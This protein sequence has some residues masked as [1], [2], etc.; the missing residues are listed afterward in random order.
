MSNKFKRLEIANWRQFSDV[1][2]DFDERMTI[3]TGANGAGKTTILN[4]LS[5]HFGWS[6]NFIGTRSLT[7]R[8]AWKYFSG[9][10]RD[11][12]NLDENAQQTIGSLTYTDGQ[13]SQLTVSP[14][15]TE[16]FQVQVASQ[17]PVSGIYITSHRPVYSYQRVDQIPTTIIAADQLF[18]DYVS[19]LR[20][21]YTPQ[22][23]IQSPSFRLKTALISLATFGYGNKA[24]E[25][26]ENA[27][28][29]FE[30]FQEVLRKILPPDLEFREIRI[31][32]PDVLIHCKHHDFSIDAASG[33]VSALIDLAW[34]I[35]MKGQSTDDFVVVLDEPENHLHPRLQRTVLPS[36]ID[37]FPQAQFIAATHNPFV[38]TSVADSS[39]VVLDFQDGKVVSEN[40][41]A[42]DK[43]A[44]ANQVLMDVL[45]V[46]FP[47][48]LWV[49]TEVDRIV[50]SLTNVELSKEILSR[51]RQQLS[52]LGLGDMFPEVI[53]RLVTTK[54][55]KQ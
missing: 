31:R 55:I 23:R 15:V 11:S 37:A 25:P 44:S 49:E 26:D 50:G 48:P 43:A 20:Q 2:V 8:G 4:L 12:F 38:V 13:T 45:G 27:R 53:E 41:S 28:E 47:M 33:G 18:E 40:L 5:R 19:N 30:S 16:N 21:Y 34:Q 36:L 51:T 39:V 22:A 29:M 54:E 6:I 32:L 3:L 1:T 14:Q 17:Q 10:N 42:F 46:P 35:H 9:I 52:K 24:V 7:K